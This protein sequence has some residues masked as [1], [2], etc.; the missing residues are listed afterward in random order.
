M[1]LT[2]NEVSRE[3]LQMKI[4][5]ILIGFITFSAIVFLIKDEGFFF[6]IS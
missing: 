1:N 5:K 6:N 4:F 3:K 2:N